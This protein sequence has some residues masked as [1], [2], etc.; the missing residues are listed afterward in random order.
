MTR[1]RFKIIGGRTPLRERLFDLGPTMSETVIR[2]D[3]IASFGERRQLMLPP[4]N[5]P[6]TGVHEHNRRSAATRIA[7]PDPTSRQIRKR[8]DRRHRCLS[9]QPDCHDGTENHEKSGP[10]HY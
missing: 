2:D 3:A 6:R 5:A 10:A 9:V 8:F 1:K 7:V 4:K